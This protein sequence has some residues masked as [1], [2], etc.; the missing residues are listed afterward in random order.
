MVDDEAVWLYEEASG[1]WMYGDG[2]RLTTYAVGA[3]PGDPAES[4]PPAAETERKASPGARVDTAT[5]GGRT[6][7]APG[8]GPGREPGRVPGG[9]GREP[10]QVVAPPDGG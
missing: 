7:G 5:A 1:R 2:T 9:E 4:E 10:T 6:P 3:G 8:H